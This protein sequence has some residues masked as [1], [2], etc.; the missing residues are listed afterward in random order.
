MHDCGLEASA[1]YAGG[2]KRRPRLGRITETRHGVRV[3]VYAAGVSAGAPDFAAKADTLRH[4]FGCESVEVTT[5]RK[6]VILD[7]LWS[8]PLSKPIPVSAL[9]RP[10]KRGHVVVGLDGPGD[11][12]EKDMGLSNLVVGAPGAGKT[13]EAWTLLHGLQTA[14]IPFRVRAFDPKGGMALALLR[15][16]CHRYVSDPSSWD[17]FLGEAIRDMEAR[18][19]RMAAAG[20]DEHVPTDVEP[21]DVMIVDELVTA[22]LMGGTGSKV[23]IGKQTVTAEKAFL[24]F[25]SQ[26]RAAG[27]TVYAGT[28]I[29]A[30]EVLGPM[31]DLFGYT[32]ILRVGPTE[33]AAVD[34]VLGSSAHKLY[35]AHRLTPRA[36][37]GIGWMRTDD[38]VR[39]YRAAYLT[40]DQR[41]TVARKLGDEQRRRENT[42]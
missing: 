40:K 21:L 8:D 16:R 18:M 22:L 20:L 34:I 35:P 13:T 27:F 39:R 9:P 31:R 24:I 11:P 14:G 33:T 37:A 5:Y 2:A 19:Q 17:T 7:L 36:T 10:T 32:S 6:S 42:Q 3:R 29:V 38:G 25:L 15:G 1:A 28:Q 23:K 4:G 26:C 41:Q 12:V 30:K